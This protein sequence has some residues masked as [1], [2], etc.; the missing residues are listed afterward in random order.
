MQ[1]WQNLLLG[2]NTLPLFTQLLHIYHIDMITHTR[3][4]AF[5]RPVVQDWLGKVNN[6][7]MNW[8]TF[9]LSWS[10]NRLS[11]SKAFCIWNDHST[12]LLLFH[13]LQQVHKS[14]SHLAHFRHFHWRE[15]QEGGATTACMCQW[16]EDCIWWLAS[17]L[18]NSLWQFT[19]AICVPIT[20][21]SK[22]CQLVHQRPRQALS[23]LCDNA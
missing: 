7:P 19:R 12:I 23:S 14:N 8:W 18:F 11:L 10:M 9:K 4:T 20:C 13:Y 21:S 3:T 17:A 22:G 1:M 2:H 16:S 5:N 6:T 15:G